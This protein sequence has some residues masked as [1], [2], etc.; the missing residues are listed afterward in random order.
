MP[1]FPWKDLL[2]QWSEEII[3][4]GDLD[5]ELAHA[6][7]A[8]GWLGHPGATE[9]EISA[10]EARLGVT[11][12][13]SY[14]EFLQVSN[15]WRMTTGFV[16]RLRPANEVQWFAAEDRETVDAWMAAGRDGTVSDEEYLVYGDSAVQPLRAGY[17]QSALAIS[18]Y[19][20]G[21]Y[22]LNPQTVTT[23]GEWEAWF[24]AHWVPGADRYRSFWELMAAEHDHFLYALKS[25]RGE[26]TPRAAPSLDV[27]AEDLDALL[28]ALQDPAQRPA[29][30][31]ALG[32]LRDKR[33][34]VPVLKVFQDRRA[35]LFTRECAARTLGE[36]RDPRAVAPLIDAFRT[37]SVEISDMQLATLLKRRTGQ[38]HDATLDELL[39]TMSIQ[40]MINALEPLLGAAMAGH[41]RATVTPEAVGKAVS[42]RL[43]YAAYQ[44]LLALGD[45]ALPGLLDALQDAD[46]GVRR[47]TAIALCHVRGRDEVFERLLVAFDDPDPSVRSSVAANIEQLFDSR[48]VDPLL[49]ALQDVDSTVRAHAARS[50]GVMATRSDADRIAKALGATSKRDPDAGVRRAAARALDRLGSTPGMTQGVDA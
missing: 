47:H 1:S 46:P 36:L 30:L 26:P 45:I 37:A 12:P 2:A 9:E 29:A 3:R 19:G 10:A 48:A 16:R 15:G 13:P 27:D 41:L 7:A 25:S 44:G 43:A 32:N 40:E 38:T 23:E 24:F 34:F 18:D 39:G 8:S 22:L 20:D 33:A 6:V 31:Q 50:L 35:D 5:D 4:S 11:F 17:L 42:E 14:R 21:I 28:A 49:K